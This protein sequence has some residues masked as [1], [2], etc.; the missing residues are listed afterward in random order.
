MVFKHFRWRILFRTIILGGLIYLL[1]VNL[2]QSENWFGSIIIGLLIVGS[3]SELIYYVEGTNRKL[4]RFLE[5]IRYSDFTSNFARDSK[6]GKS[7]SDLNEAFNAVLEA[8]RKTRKEKEEHFQYLN[9]VVQ[10]VTTGLLSYDSTGQIGIVNNA[11]KRYLQTPQLRSVDDIKKINP[12]L[13]EGI[14]EIKPGEKRL[15]ECDHSAQ[16]SL[17]AT[18]IKL[19]GKSFKLIS[20]QNIKSEL[21]QN[22]IQAWRNL[23]KVLR[24]EIMNSVTP[25]ASLTSTLSDILNEEID[26]SNGVNAL[27][28][29]SLV[30]I[31]DG[32]STIQ[33][34]TRGLVTFVDAYRDYTNLPTPNPKVVD[35][36]QMIDHVVH[37]TAADMSEAGI[38]PE[39]SFPNQNLE[40]QLDP[41]LIEMVLINL[42]KNARE[43]LE[44]TKNP[45]INVQVSSPSPESVFVSITDNG[46]GIVKEA[47]DRIFIPFYTTKKQG[48]GIGLALSR[49]I[50]QQHG[51][52]L[53]VESVPD[54]ET[55]FVLGFRK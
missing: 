34:R 55:K 31:Q 12:K 53:S 33:N 1:F 17:N 30:D 13:H 41:D 50:M 16:Y 14:S 24:H 20:L 15:I 52:S 40:L 32:L 3:L 39:L 8:F 9:T 18:L 26:R 25:I 54:K 5:S 44:L 49:Q 43:A 6:S 27:P 42:L 28:E 47:L 11:A 21:E 36:R 38:K 29:E 51:G 45:E 37:L 7:F 4:N 2:N 23:T 48:S 22:E 10:H 46:P 35:L 19:Q